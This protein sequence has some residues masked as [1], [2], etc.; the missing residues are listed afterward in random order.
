MRT[1]E[2]ASFSISEK[3]GP[4]PRFVLLPVTTFAVVKQLAGAVGKVQGIRLGPAAPNPANILLINGKL[5]PAVAFRLSGKS[6]T[7]VITIGG[8]L[9]LSSK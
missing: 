6:S 3:F 9:V 1:I 5:P 4:V 8:P 2:T 7:R